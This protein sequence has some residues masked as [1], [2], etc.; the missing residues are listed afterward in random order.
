VVSETVTLTSAAT[1]EGYLITSI[2][3]RGT[4][5]LFTYDSETDTIRGD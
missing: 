2:S 3:S 4:G 5:K 1:T